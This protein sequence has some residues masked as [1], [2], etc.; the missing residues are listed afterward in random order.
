MVA[1]K[2]MNNLSLA[3][4]ALN[5][6]SAA[7]P[8]DSFTVETRYED[9]LRRIA[10][11]KDKDEQRKR[12]AII[13]LLLLFAFLAYQEG[14]EAGGAEIEQDQLTLAQQTL[15]TQFA[16]AQ[17]E[18]AAGL[19]HAMSE[20]DKAE[21]A[22]EQANARLA[23]A[24]SETGVSPETKQADIA[25]AEAEVRKAAEVM[26]SKDAAVERRITAW[27][28]T[29]RT[30]RAMGLAWAAGSVQGQWFYGDT[31]HCKSCLWLNG[32]IHPVSWYI[33]NNYI[34]GQPGSGTLE[35]GGWNCK[36]GVYAVNDIGRRLL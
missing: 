36:C 19:A 12:D 17:T 31:Q 28:G 32:Q 21:R 6:M 25:T 16:V 13:L 2:E 26:H 7:L 1:E 14:V 8:I 29:L 3:S 23:T 15:I 33:E 27:K 9:D 20:A 30:M 34:P 22:V 10:E 35:C 5:R 24:R 18:Y 11:D 4:S